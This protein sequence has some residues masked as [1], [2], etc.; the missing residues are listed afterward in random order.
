MAM[1]LR[2]G[3]TN[4]SSIRNLFIHNADR[5]P[6][7]TDGTS[8]FYANNITYNHSKK[9]YVEIDGILGSAQQ[10][11][12]VNNNW[13]A[14]ANTI[15][16]ASGV[17]IQV[18]THANSEI[19]QTG[20]ILTGTG[21]MVEDDTAEGVIVTTPAIWDSSVTLRTAAELEAYLVPRV[22][23]RA[24]V[25]DDIDSRIISEFSTRTGVRKNTVE[26]AGGWDLSSGSHSLTPPTDVTTVGASGY[27]LVEEWVHG[28]S[29]LVEVAEVGASTTTTTPG[30]TTTTTT[31]TTTA[32]LITFL[33]DERFESGYDEV[34]SLGE[35]KLDAGS[36][37]NEDAPSTWATDPAPFGWG[38]KCL[39]AENPA[40]GQCWIKHQPSWSGALH[41][42][43]E[44]V[45][46]V[47]NML[48]GEV[49]RFFSTNVGSTIVFMLEASREA[50][51][52]NLRV[53][54]NI[55][56]DGSGTDSFYFYIENNVLYRHEVKYDMVNDLWEWKVNGVTQ[57]SGALSG[58][59]P[60]T[61]NNVFLG[62]GLSAGTPRCVHYFDRFGVST[63][64]WIG[65][66]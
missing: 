41:F 48:P 38:A 18:E 6:R 36:S 20:N 39:R 46:A 64:G 63:D 25:R 13:I 30:P 11:S 51:T 19:Y 31:T 24:A 35:N 3:T 42:R 44:H 29:A 49:N 8:V 52:N 43:L 58:T 61:I 16:G 66:A 26:G 9:H 22:G 1:L 33:F 40:G 23:A 60:T 5:N 57:A 12:A 56:N 2:S 14:G 65:D 47:D 34:W 62:S 28:Y 45:L 37:L 32:S 27:L 21:P 7:I 4:F 53:R 55:N 15:A 10:F 17:H 59:H 54:F 50:V